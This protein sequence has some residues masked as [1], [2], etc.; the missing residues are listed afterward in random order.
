MIA[1]P[2]VGTRNPRTKDI[3]L[4]TPGE[5]HVPRVFFCIEK[6]PT[7]ARI[8]DIVYVLVSSG[9]DTLLEQAVLSAESLRK[10]M[11]DAFVKVLIDKGTQ[12]TL[13][14]A[15]KKLYDVFDEV[16]SVDTPGETSNKNRSRQLKTTMY[17]YMEHDFLYID[18]DTL[19]CEDLST[20]QEDAG[21]APIAAVAD[22]HIPLS[23]S[24]LNRKIE[25]HS[26]RCGFHASFDDIHF[27]GGFFFVR[28]CAVSAEFFR[29]WNLLW[30]EALE[31]R[32]TQDQ[33]SLNEVNWRLGG[34]I[35]ELDGSYNCQIRRY[36]T[37]LPYLHEA[38]MIHYFASNRDGCVPYDLSDNAL[39]RHALDEV[40]PAELQAILDK[41]K[42]ALHKIGYIVADRGVAKMLLWTPLY[43]W[44]EEAILKIRKKH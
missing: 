4:Y 22:L 21:D 6:I 38:K 23:A 16:L 44:T 39:L 8:M 37:G 28:K 30:R 15:R 1:V 24:P 20:V 9:R 7:F 11:P 42:S 14:G 32:V 31:H 12:E 40:R 35:K 41:P 25:R 26:R 18:S 27:N 5:H 17:D 19:V 34:V 36:G 33:T 13:S 43:K 10:V 3:G 29:Q 2:L